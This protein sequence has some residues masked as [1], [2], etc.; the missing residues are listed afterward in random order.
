MHI[1]IADAVSDS[2]VD[3]FEAAGHRVTSAPGLKGDALT[4]ALAEH[5]PDVLVVRSTKVTAAD[6][7][8]SSS[9]ELVVRAG[10]GTDTIDV[11][12][13]SGRGIFV[14]NCPGKNAAAVAELAF[15]LIL[16]LDRRIA[17][18]VI[19]AR[20]G[21]WRKGEFSKANGVKGQTL[22][23][24]GMGSIGQEMVQ[25]AK[26][27]EMPVVAWSRSLTEEKAREL[28]IRRAASPLHVAQKADVVSVHLAATPH[29]AHFIDR[30]FLAA[31]KPGATLINT[32]RD[33][34]LDESAL[35]AVIDQKGFRVAT[36]VP[37]G[38]PADKHTDGF[39]HPLA[40]HPN[41]YITHHIGASTEQAAAAI[42][43]EAVRVVLA[44]AETGRV[45]NVVNIAVKTRATHLLTVRH[46]DRVGV[47]AGVLD[48]AREAG[49]NVQE[50]ENLVFEGAEAAV[51]RIRFD[52]TPTDAALER[53]RGTEHVLAASVLPLP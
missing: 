38:E 46:L 43:D 13:A 1:L 36:D 20:A 5:Q 11:D 17:D 9:L 45:P 40:Q 2:A 22:G 42:A 29:T 35:A 39:A 16:A 48:A 7:D 8:A 41:V 51:A 10:A 24:I 27:F 26:A 47:L 19:E 30:E 33:K 25:R 21:R 18:N 15:G 12:G 49:W 23:L 52:G 28:G 4:S 3:Q 44:Y 6:L 53:V 50:M 34:V 32:A 31:M 14:A 37:A